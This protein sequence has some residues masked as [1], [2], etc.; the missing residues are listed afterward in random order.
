MMNDNIIRL[1]MNCRNTDSGH[2]TNIPPAGIKPAGGIVIKRS[3]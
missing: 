1:A 2:F 3:V